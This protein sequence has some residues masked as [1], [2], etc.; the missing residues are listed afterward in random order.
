MKVK[1]CRFVQGLTKAETRGCEKQETQVHRVPS[2]T[3]CKGGTT[4]GNNNSPLVLII[5]I[6]C[7]PQLKLD[8]QKHPQYKRF[9]VFTPDG[10][11][12]TLEN[13]LIH[14]YSKNTI[15]ALEPCYS[16]ETYPATTEKL[17]SPV[18]MH[19]KLI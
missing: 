18:L 14:S 12:V 6:E 15:H 2:P 16:C 10:Q 9:P 4:R 13:F 3:L 7:P 1:L 5:I 17:P 19:H 8:Y 11:W